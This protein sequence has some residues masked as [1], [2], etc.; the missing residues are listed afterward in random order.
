MS[1]GLWATRVVIRRT[2]AARLLNR[3]HL[4]LASRLAL[5]H[6][7]HLHTGMVI[8]LVRG[9][10]AISEVVMGLSSGVVLRPRRLLSRLCMR[11][12]RHSR[13]ELALDLG[14]DSLHL[15]HHLSQPL[16]IIRVGGRHLVQ[17][18]LLVQWRH[19]NYV[20]REG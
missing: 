9:G 4:L 8:D 1:R 18:H 15:S 11:A 19:L 2:Q 17:R 12:H 6:V 3:R 7:V 10:W 16:G 13:V 14:L 5:R 20:S